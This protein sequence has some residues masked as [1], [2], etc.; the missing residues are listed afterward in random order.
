MN[1]LKAINAAFTKFWRWIKETAWVQPLLIVGGIFAIIFSISRFNSWFSVMA[2]GTSTGYFN[3]FRVSLENE[4]QEGYETAADKLTTSINDY[5]FNNYQS[6]EELKTTLEN[7]GVINDYG[8]KYF[9]LFVEEDC[10]GCENAERAFKLLEDGWN[11]ATFKFEDGIQ[12][13][14]KSIYADELSTNDRDY[15]LEEDSRA[16]YRYT[17]K[18]DDRDFWAR[19][20]GRLEGRPYKDN[21]SV[22]SSKYE[23][24]ENAE[25]SSWE[26]PTIFL[27]DWTE[28]AFNEGHV[29]ITEVLFGFSSGS[30]DYERA[31]LLQDMWNHVPQ[32]SE[33]S[34]KDVDNPFR[35]EFQA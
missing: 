1:I 32:N 29:G 21:K 33:E 11:K 15:D 12:L 4:G 20:A 24:L 31:T 17:K 2:V 28:A 19:A 26:T 8:M 27:V 35:D 14:I 23:S 34:S 16:F 9:L 13:N 5:S 10:A 25:A 3:S 18:F 7:A 22:S 30:T 6:Y